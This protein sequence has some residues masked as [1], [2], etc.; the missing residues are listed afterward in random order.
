MKHFF[1]LLL[2]TISSSAFSQKIFNVYDGFTLEL[3]DSVAVSSKK[4]KVV[5]STVSLGIYSVTNTERGTQ[6]TFKKPGYQT[7][8]FDCSDDGNSSLKIILA[9]TESLLKS[10]R[11][12]LPYY[13]TET[14]F[15]EIKTTETNTNATDVP[16]EKDTVDEN[17][18][19][20]Y[21][22]EVADYPGGKAA[23]AKYIQDN[24]EY[25]QQAFDLKISGKVFVQF[26]IST[27][28]AVSN[29][30]VVRGVNLPM[31]A[32]AYR[33]VKAMPAWTPGRLKGKPVNCVFN[34]P[35]SFKMR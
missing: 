29:V 18:V 11:S 9:P 10:Y 21:V 16:V 34:L 17:H 4:K 30:R 27:T 1:F 22:E 20:T 12:K 19:Y 32:E 15:E 33:V 5:V 14:F 2:I 3:I 13:K 26:V 25:P 24:V 28:G 23:L 7:Q 31:D 6:L 35:I 8:Y